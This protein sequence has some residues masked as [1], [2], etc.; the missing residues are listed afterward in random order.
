[1]AFP[2]TKK[3]AIIASTNIPKLDL[4][5][6]TLITILLFVRLLPKETEEKEAITRQGTANTSI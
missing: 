4:G 1:L 2:A 6:T 3:W 5:A